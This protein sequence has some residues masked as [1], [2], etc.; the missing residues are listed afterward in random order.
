MLNKK[1]IDMKRLII[2]LGFS[3]A[4]I[5]LY[6]QEFYT[7]ANGAKRICGVSTTKMFVQLETFSAANYHE[8]NTNSNNKL[9]N[10]QLNKK[11]YLCK[12]EK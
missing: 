12:L 4:S 6:G 11:L 9:P 5:Y 8:L 1:Y 7:Y 10:L 2:F 3:L